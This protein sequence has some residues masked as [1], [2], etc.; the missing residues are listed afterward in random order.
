[1]TEKE[2]TADEIVTVAPEQG[3]APSSSEATS[4]FAAVPLAPNL[5]RSSGKGFALTQRLFVLA[6]IIVVLISV[7]DSYSNQPHSQPALAQQSFDALHVQTVPSQTSLSDA[8]NL[9]EQR[10]IIG[11]PPPVDRTETNE[12][13]TVRGWRAEVREYWELKGSSVI[14]G[15][16]NDGI[17]EAIVFDNR[18]E[19]LQFFRA[20]QTVE[21]A[22]ADVDI[23]RVDPDR[24]ELRLGDE[25]FV[26]D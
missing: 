10:R 26:L 17:L 1:M 13:A 16:Q 7:Y 20:G 21:I 11:P 4:T 15:V 22:G 8:I 19:R 6:A 9:Y 14:H 18:A 24:V 2:T 12:V 3:A 5:H 25:V 23:S